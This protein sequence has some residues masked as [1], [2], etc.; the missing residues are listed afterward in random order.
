MDVNKPHRVQIGESLLLILAIKEGY[1]DIAMALLLAGANVYAK[2]GGERTA[3]HWAC[4]RGWEEVVQA[5]IDGKSRLNEGD[6]CHDTPLM[7]SEQWGNRAISMRLLRSGASCEG[8]A[9]WRLHDL[10]LHACHER[11]LS[12]VRGLLKNG[13]VVSSLSKDMQEALLH[14]ASHEGDIAICL[15]QPFR[16]H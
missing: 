11:D 5:L 12:V 9:E 15:S 16:E 6:T 8:L 3:L 4:R 1:Q 2:D 13:Y 10:F 14:H 7:L